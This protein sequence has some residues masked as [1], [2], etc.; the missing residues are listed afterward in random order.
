MSIMFCNNRVS[1]SVADTDT[2]TDEDP[3]DNAT[4]CDDL[5]YGHTQTYIYVFLFISLIIG[6]IIFGRWVSSKI[7]DNSGIPNNV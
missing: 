2:D 3:L 7:V 5:Y 6:I 4:F 1:S